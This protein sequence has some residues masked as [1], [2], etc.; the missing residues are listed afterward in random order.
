MIMP[1]IITRPIFEKVGPNTIFK[2]VYSEWSMMN[3]NRPGFFNGHAGL[4]QYLRYHNN[5]FTV[6]PHIRVEYFEKPEYRNM[7]RVID[8][9]FQKHLPSPNFIEL[10]SMI[11]SAS[12][13][14]EAEVIA[15]V[16]FL[17]K[18][19]ELAPSQEVEFFVQKTEE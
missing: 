7:F 11:D 12:G 4:N 17:N 5:Y 15:G 6:M 8:S 10:T 9:Y 19:S 16:K 2:P 14:T 18:I 13:Q 3:L 1:E